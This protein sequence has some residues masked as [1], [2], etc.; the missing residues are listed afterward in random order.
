MVDIKIECQIFQNIGSSMRA[1]VYCG[2][3]SGKEQGQNNTQQR[4]GIITCEQET[5]EWE[6]NCPYV[7]YYQPRSSQ[8]MGAS[9]LSSQGDEAPV[10]LSSN[11]NESVPGT[12]LV[13]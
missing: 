13:D 9:V 11:G 6:Q 4:K 10:V 12:R 8:T 5:V 1:I 3:S 2:I 7:L